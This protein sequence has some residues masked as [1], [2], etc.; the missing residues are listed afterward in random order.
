M[1]FDLYFN[2]LKL[3][4]NIP[5]WKVEI[6]DV[7]QIFKND[8][9]IYFVCKQFYRRYKISDVLYLSIII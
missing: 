8:C 4:N 6:T 1:C 7:I 3:I 5:T 9:Y 2:K